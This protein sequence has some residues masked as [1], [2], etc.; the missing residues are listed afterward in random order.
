M[1]FSDSMHHMQSIAGSN[2]NGMLDSKA[3]DVNS[4]VQVVNHG[5]A[6]IKGHWYTQKHP[7][8]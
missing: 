8:V 6:V 5:V 7:Y 3:V 1:S 2:I 4:I